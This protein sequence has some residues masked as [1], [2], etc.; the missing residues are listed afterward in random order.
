MT[1]RFTR[2]I[3]LA[4]T[5]AVS[6]TTTALAQDN[7][8]DGPLEVVMHTKPGGTSDIFI[9]TLAQSLEPQIGQPIVVTNAPGGGGATQMAK[10]RSAKADGLT[11][12]INTLT[13]FTSMQT[14]LKGTFSPDDFS[15]IASVQE[16]PILF[17]VRE[18]SPYQTFADVIAAARENPATISIGGFGPV[19]SMQHIGTSI[20]ENATDTKFNWIGYESTPDI[21]T[22]LLGGHVDIGVSNL[23]PT[24]PYF[25]AGRIRGLGVLNN[26]RLEG[27]PELATFGEQGIDVDTSWIQVRGVFGP[28]GMPMELQQQIAD[29]FHDAMKADSYQNYARSTGV[30]DS[31]MEPAD[32][33]DFVSN[34][35]EVA[36]TQLTAAGVLN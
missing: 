7:W 16:D 22:A 36:R 31:W 11:L 4:A 15:W 32:Y 8:P 12:G 3:A 34:I 30:S 9:R 23:G 13:H 2:A 10:V 18:D 5:A 28:K 17:F 29:A 35:S 33:S 25:E 6:V 20:L 19:G 21:L 1:F 14:N 26:E 24:A 27:L